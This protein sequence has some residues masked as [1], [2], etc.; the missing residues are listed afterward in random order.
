MSLPSFENSRTVALC[1]LV[2]HAAS[3]LVP[4][5]RRAEWRAEWDGELHE[6]WRRARVSGASNNSNHPNA[7]A[8][9]HLIRSALGALPHAVA[10]LGQEW[11]PSI[12]ANE[13]R[14]AA[15]F[16]GR[17]PGY[18]LTT[19]LLISLGVGANTTVFTLVN[20]VMLRSPR[21]IADPAG[22]AQVGRGG[23]DAR[24]FDSWSYPLFLELRAR[25]SAFT[26]LAAYATHDVTFGRDDDVCTGRRT[27]RVV[28][29]F[30][31]AR[32]VDATRSRF[33]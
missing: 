7:R 30:P 8:R 33:R 18:S 12:V 14:N 27:A 31:R 21:G 25:N 22:L 9:T 6:Q 23:T 24:D 13:V 1:R 11:S 5:G 2:V 3:L 28:E 20:A 4:G 16:L 26:D 19:A 29:L 15:R 10:E 32:R 17:N